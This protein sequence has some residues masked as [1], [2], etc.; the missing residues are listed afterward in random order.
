M[1]SHDGRLNSCQYRKRLCI[2]YESR[3]EETD[4]LS[5]EDLQNPPSIIDAMIMKERPFVFTNALE[6]LPIG[7]TFIVIPIVF[8]SGWLGCVLPS[9]F[10]LERAFQGTLDLVSLPFWLTM[11]QLLFVFLIFFVFQWELLLRFAFV[12]GVPGDTFVVDARSSHKVCFVSILFPK[13]MFFV[14]L[15]RDCFGSCN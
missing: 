2:F 4:L 6:H 3:V 1:F 13:K 5:E 15:D 10:V 7:V 12:F 11:F 9:A 14:C 8:T